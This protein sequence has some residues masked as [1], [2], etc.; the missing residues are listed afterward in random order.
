MKS[1]IIKILLFL[2]IGLECLALTNRERIEKDLR[3]LNINDSKIIA[4]TITI[5]E[6]IGDKLLQG[7]GVEVLLKDLKSL[8][9]ENPKNFY[10]SYQI[11][12]YY[13]ETEKNIEEVKKNKKYFDLYIENVPQEDEK[14]SMKMLYYEKVGDKVN[15]KKYYDKFFKKTSG[16]GLGVLA[17]T[18]YK[19]DAASIK[20]DFALALDLFKK[21]IED[22][23]KDEVTEEELFLIQNSYDS[24]V[25]Q[26]M[27]EKKEYQKIID[28]YLNNMANQNYYTTGVMMK[29]GDRLTSQFYIITNLNEKFLNKNKENLKKI[30]NTKL[31]R[32]L[33]KFGK[34]IVVNK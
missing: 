20:K 10:I 21:E 31:Y 29:Y 5:D 32:E 3:K 34:V 26:E 22:G 12:R 19:K 13:L 24:L 33:E 9:A 28:Y 6:K 7:E 8:V 23:N 15:F 25:I 27:L 4:Q 30:T 2:F 17:R 1:K 14:L 11:A 18:K 16:K